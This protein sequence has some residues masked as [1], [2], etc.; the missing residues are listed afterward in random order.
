MNKRMARFNPP[1]ELNLGSSVAQR[2]P[3]LFNELA[4]RYLANHS[5][6]LS[7]S[8]FNLRVHH[9]SEQLLGFF[10]LQA[11]KDI[12]PA[13]LHKFIYSLEDKGLQAHK[14]QACLVTFRV[15][16]KYA[17]DQKWLFD[18]TMTKPLVDPLL[19]QFGE[20]SF[21]SEDEFHLL[22]QDLV[23]EVTEQTFH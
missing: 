14:I 13:R 12:R 11:L 22:Y 23:Q 9:L 18:P 19:G 8:V 5:A 15:C 6:T 4:M 17:L 20:A 1:R 16:M 10:G 7:A 2:R 3:M 21:M